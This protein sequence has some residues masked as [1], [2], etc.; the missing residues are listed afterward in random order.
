MYIK[1]NQAGAARILVPV[2]A[3][4]IAVILVLSI[5]G[6]RRSGEF[7]LGLMIPAL[8]FFLIIL[9]SFTVFAVDLY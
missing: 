8:A 1:Q 5:L 9:A 2:L 7:N 4:F 3:V 6:W